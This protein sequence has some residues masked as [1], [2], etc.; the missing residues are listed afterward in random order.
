MNLVEAT[1]AVI[2]VVPSTSSRHLFNFFTEFLSFMFYV[3]FDSNKSSVFVIH[4]MSLCFL[5]DTLVV[6]VI[7]RVGFGINTHIFL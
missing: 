6:S 7:G 1:Q 5:T 2:I 4:R 3:L